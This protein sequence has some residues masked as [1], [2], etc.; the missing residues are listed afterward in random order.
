MQLLSEELFSETTVGCTASYFVK[1]IW[2]TQ[3]FCPPPPYFEAVY[4]FICGHRRVAVARYRMICLVLLIYFIISIPTLNFNGPSNIVMWGS[5]SLPKCITLAFLLHPYT[6]TSSCLCYFTFNYFYS[7]HQ[8]RL[9][10]SLF[11]FLCRNLFTLNRQN[12]SANLSF[13]VDL[14]QREFGISPT[15]T[16]SEMARCT[17]DREI[18]MAAYLSQFYELFHDEKLPET[19]RYPFT[20]YQPGHSKTGEKWISCITLAVIKY[21]ILTD[22][23]STVLCCQY[24]KDDWNLSPLFSEELP[25]IPKNTLVKPVPFV[26]PVPQQVSKFYYIFISHGIL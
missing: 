14:A 2:C 16:V 12:A 9:V 8:I 4:C 20:N 11:H 13:V 26:P 10:L 5:P 6:Y 15:M 17:P 19:R 1:I 25:F 3:W 21:Y 24:E 7:Q 18:A 22:P 23:L